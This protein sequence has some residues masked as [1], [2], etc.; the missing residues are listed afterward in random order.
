MHN[1][2][3]TCEKDLIARGFSFLE[4]LI[5]LLILSITLLGIGVTAGRA[6][7][8]NHDSYLYSIANLQLINL[9]ERA[10]VRVATNEF[11]AWN[12]SNVELLPKGEGDYE[13]GVMR[14]CWWSRDLQK[15]ECLNNY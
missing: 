3:R 2:L 9:Y 5:A 4:L 14:V 13:G 1:L 7:I 15:M 10:K 11:S 8:L 12:Q 6:L